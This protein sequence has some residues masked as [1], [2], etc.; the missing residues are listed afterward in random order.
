[1]QC[2]SGDIIEL[3][4]TVANNDLTWCR[5][6][7]EH[8]VGEA[9]FIPLLL[10]ELIFTYCI[11]FQLNDRAEYTRFFPNFDFLHREPQN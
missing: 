11:S 1:M 2:P 5:F 9:V 7:D 3:H 10:E 4:L 8:F 6:K